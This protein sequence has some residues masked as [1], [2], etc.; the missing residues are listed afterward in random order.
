MMLGRPAEVGGES[1]LGAIAAVGGVTRRLRD[2]VEH[3]V[4]HLVEQCTVEVGLAVEVLVQHRLGDAGGLGDVV[5]RGP[6]VPRTAELV[7]R[8]I[9]DLLSAGVGGESGGSHGLPKSNP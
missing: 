4:A 6:V 3:P 1:L 5:H 8:D 7:D 9:E 2:R